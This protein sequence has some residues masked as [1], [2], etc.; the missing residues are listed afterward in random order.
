M[1]GPIPSQL[2]EMTDLTELYLNDNDLTGPIPS[3]LGL[4]NALTT[5]RLQ[6]GNNLSADSPPVEVC[7]LVQRLEFTKTDITT[8]PE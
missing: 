1:G 3:Q 6:M 7:E 2:G 4:L 8:C 5:L